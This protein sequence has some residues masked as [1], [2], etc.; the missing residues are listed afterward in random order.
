MKRS[1]DS[2]LGKLGDHKRSTSLPDIPD[3]PQ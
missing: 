2:T 1:L 3:E